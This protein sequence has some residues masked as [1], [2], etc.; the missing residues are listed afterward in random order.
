M[1][2]YN[3]HTGLKYLCR[4]LTYTDEEAIQYLGSGVK[5]MRDI[6]EHGEDKIEHW[7]ILYKCEEEKIAVSVKGGDW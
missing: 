2:K 3:K 7:S 5:W 6:K 4:K 1:I